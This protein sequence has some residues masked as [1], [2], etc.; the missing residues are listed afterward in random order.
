MNESLGLGYVFDAKDLATGVMDR[1]ANKFTEVEG[2]SSDAA[3]AMKANMAEFGAGMSLFGTGLATLGGAGAL[4]NISGEFTQAVRAAGKVAGA[5]AEEMNQFASAAIDAGIAT[6]FDPTQ[7]VKALGDIAQA[8]YSANESMALLR[9]TLDLAAGSLGQLSPSAAAG[10]ATQTMKAFGVEASQASAMVDKLLS[11][12]NLF[13]LSADELP[14]ALGTASRGAGVLKQSLDETLIALG[15]VKNVIP[16]VERASTA[17]AVSMERMVNPEVAN[18]LKAQGVA[19]ADAAGNFRPFLDIVQDLIPALGKMST[20]QQRA[21]FLSETF[22]SEALG[23]LQAILT[24]VTNGIKANTG[25]TL[26][27]AAAVDYLRTSFKNSGGAAADFSAAMLDTFEGQKTLVGGSVKTFAI[28]VGQ[29]FERALKPAVTAFLTVLNGVLAAFKALPDPVKDTL[30]RAVLFAGTLMTVLGGALAAKAA[31]GLFSAGLSAAGVTMGGFL[32]TLA[33]AAATLAA[34][35]LAV[36]GLKAAFDANIGGIGDT[37]RSAVA[38]VQLAWQALSQLFSQG[39]FS[40]A[41]LEEL[42]KV[43]NQGIQNFAI[44][45]YLV[46][47]RIEEFLSGIK[48]GFSS[49]M[50]AVGPVLQEMRAAFDEL[51]EALGFVRETV[52]P[53]DAGAAF[54]AY[55]A[56][57]LSVGKALAHAFGFVVQVFT[58]VIRVGTGLVS[59]FRYLG[60]VVAPL[61]DAILPVGQALL[62]L[63]GSLSGST[64]GG[65]AQALGNVLQALGNVLMAVGNVILWLAE[66]AVPPLKVA[67]SVIAD[68]IT[69]VARLLSGLVDFIGGVFTGNWERAFSGLAKVVVGVVNAIVVAVGS[70]AQALVG[71][72]DTVAAIFGSKLDLAGSVRGFFDQINGEFGKAF[73]EGGAPAPG[74]PQGADTAAAQAFLAPEPVSPVS[75]A[76]ASSQ[77]SNAAATSQLADAAAQL[78]ATKEGPANLQGAI[79]LDGEQVGRVIARSQ[80]SDASRSFMSVEVDQ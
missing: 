75:P 44:R 29:P 14:L 5:S 13:A 63:I 24:Q 74:A 70:V 20:E 58:G 76:L 49:A 69:V 28:L 72:V 31:F 30:A 10:L 64:G 25:E 39:G 36:V 19:V 2:R 48:S 33:P 22:G 7:A 53:A 34:I 56:A 43:E 61:L 40:G 42:D 11:S 23:G 41:V 51:G 46:V 9:P 50:S 60:N 15:L 73:G 32:A 57:G 68:V 59:W 54:D 71:L 80:R 77:A 1:V 47:N 37:V 67:F 3:K 17:V 79:Y 16:S 78:K 6:Q 4:A 55:G 12:A 66:V 65:W 26:K 27:G 62:T 52:D 45:V 35:T 8:G 18:K 21:A 38:S